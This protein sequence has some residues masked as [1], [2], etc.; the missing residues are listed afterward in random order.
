MESNVPIQAATTRTLRNIE[1]LPG[2]R[3]LPLVGNLFQVDR[4]RVHQNVEAWGR[5][6]GPFFRFRLGAR[7]CSR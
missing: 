5:E 6:Y 4:G 7:T 1:D 3:M 2:P